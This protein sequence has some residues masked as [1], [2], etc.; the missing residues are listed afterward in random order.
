[1]F[2]NSIKELKL[3][4]TRQFANLSVEFEEV[5]AKNDFDLGLFSGNIKH[6]IHLHDNTPIRHKLRRTPLKFEGEE[7]DH[8][9]QMFEKGIIQ[10]S[11][12][13]YAAS[14]VLVRKKDGGIR[15]C[16]DYRSLNNATV[17]DAFP[18]PNISDCLDTLRGSTLMSS[19]DMAAGDW[20]IEIAE[21]DRYKTAFNTKYGLFEHIR[22]SFGLCNSPATF[23]RII[24][25]VLQ[26]LTFGTSFENHVINLRK[27]LER[28]KQYNLKLKP[29]KC[30]FFQ[31]ELK[32]LGKLVSAKGVSINPENIKAVAT[33]PVPK[34]KKEL[35]SFIGFANYHREH[36]NNFSEI[37]VP[38]HQLTG[39]K[40][41]FVWSDKHQL[42][43]ENIKKALIEAAT[44]NYPN[45]SYTFILD[46][47]SSDVSIGAEL[48]QVQEGQ[49]K[50]ISFSSKVLTPAQRKYC[51]TRKELL[52]I[53]TFTRQ[54]RHYLL[55]NSFIVRTDHNSLTWLMSFKNIEGQLDG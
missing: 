51:T 38:L 6:E 20:E 32:F 39:K 46:T 43:F 11:I 23:S 49:E 53:I 41:D 17:K 34:T 18:M 30:S 36:I 13:E 28:F 44:L 45:P 37:T 54:Y 9:K 35:E 19:V 10:K 1:M 7:A 48:S 24:Q 29:Q 2:K 40:I 42:A 47:Y 5:F 12:S 27:V 33:W 25:L 3:A 21:K 4:Q 22:L 15:Y 52:A 16:I 55:G 50:I 8:I 14:P 26:G 31:T